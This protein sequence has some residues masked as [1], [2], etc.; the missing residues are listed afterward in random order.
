VLQITSSLIIYLRFETSL[1][2]WSCPVQASDA[3]RDAVLG[4]HDASL[5][6]FAISDVQASSLALHK[7]TPENTTMIRQVW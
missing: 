5:S 6:T 1:S 2:K 3:V 7:V 4:L